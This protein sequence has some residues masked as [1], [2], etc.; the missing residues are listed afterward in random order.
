MKTL[1]LL[2]HALALLVIAGVAFVWIETRAV[3][4]LVAKGFDRGG[5]IAI[6]VHD[7]RMMVQYDATAL[8]PD[9]IVIK[10][11]D[12]PPN[13]CGVGLPNRFYSL[14]EYQDQWHWD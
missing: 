8:H 12:T 5:E 13:I 3:E 1:R 2:C 9:G 11:F 4:Y 7:G 6:F 10:D 14:T